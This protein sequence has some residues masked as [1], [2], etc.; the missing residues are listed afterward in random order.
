MC[1]FESHV[2]VIRVLKNEKVSNMPSIRTI[3]KLNNKFLEFGKVLD[4]PRIVRPKISDQMSP[5][6][7]VQFLKKIPNQA[8][9]LFLCKRALAEWQIIVELVLT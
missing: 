9:P 6:Q 4:L 2:Q 3:T 7:F 1:K 8:W 5:N